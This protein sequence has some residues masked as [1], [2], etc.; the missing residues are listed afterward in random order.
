MGLKVIDMS[1]D[2]RLKNTAD[3]PKWYGWEHTNA[4]LLGKAISPVRGRNRAVPEA[5]RLA[6]E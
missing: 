5:F 3:Y 2:F 6:V 4:E 1:A